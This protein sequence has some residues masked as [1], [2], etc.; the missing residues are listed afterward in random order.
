M[1]TLLLG[2][3]VV[4]LIVALMMS[5][6]AWRLQREENRRAAARVAALSA[7]AGVGGGP[8]KA[9]LHKGEV[10]PAEAGLHESEIGP[11]K[12]GLHAR[13]PW[14]RAAVPPLVEATRSEPE[15]ASPVVD[16]RA[17]LGSASLARSGDGRQRTLAVAAVGLFVVLA[18]GAAW[19]MSGP[20][21]STARAMGPNNP[22]ELVSLRH[23]RQATQLAISGLVRNPVTGKAV[24]H[25]S[26][27][28]FLFDQTG[29]FVTSARAPVDFVTLGVGDESPFVVTLDAP[30]TV[31][32]YRVSFRTEAGIVP[33]I[34]RRGAP[35]V[36]Q[37][38]EQPVS[39][40][41]K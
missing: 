7:A 14:A 32:R 9:G 21:G 29:T 20:R 38:G 10:G 41:L 1:D 40:R 34:D 22:L 12:A 31:A 15:T 17:F 4:S 35:P 13:A 33:H 24:D 8:A 5:V 36:A 11:A 18:V 30:A 25:L 28:V 26:A 39:V 3:T 27:V 6:S 2:V 16:A 19:S 37:T 23:D